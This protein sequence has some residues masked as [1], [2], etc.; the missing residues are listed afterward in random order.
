MSDDDSQRHVKSND[1]LYFG[2]LKLTV[3]VCPQCKAVYRSGA[4]E[5]HDTLRSHHGATHFRSEDGKPTAGSMRPHE[6][7]GW[8]RFAGGSSEW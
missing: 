4:M 7:S 3:T 5:Y 8:K 6:N 1:F 2:Q